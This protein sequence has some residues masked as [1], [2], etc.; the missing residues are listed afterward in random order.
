MKLTREMVKALVDIENAIHN[1]ITQR[2]VEKGIDMKQEEFI[3]QMLGD[4]FDF[5]KR[6]QVEIRKLYTNNESCLAHERV[7]SE[8]EAKTLFG[9]RFIRL[10]G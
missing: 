8:A 10:V 2:C 9:N 7:T 3:R 1:L 4:E 6:Y 5:R